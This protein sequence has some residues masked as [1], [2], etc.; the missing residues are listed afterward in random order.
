MVDPL[1]TVATRSS[2]QDDALKPRTGTPKIL[3]PWL[4]MDQS[5]MF[6]LMSLM[7][8]CLQRT[9]VV[10]LGNRRPSAF[11]QL[12]HPAVMPAANASSNLIAPLHAPI[13]RLTV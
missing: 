5:D 3:S 2:G 12:A 8:H 6:V 11:A 13:P 4:G 7:M 1:S 10:W 9:R